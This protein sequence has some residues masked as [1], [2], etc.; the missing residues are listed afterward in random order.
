MERFFDND[1]EKENEFFDGAFNDD[2][3]DIDTDFDEEGIAY[4]D[5][6]GVMQI[7]NI[8]LART[9]HKQHIL[10]KAV[11]I[12][13]KSFFWRFK[14]VTKKMRDIHNVYE[15]LKVI[16]EDDGLEEATE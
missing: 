11:E 15:W 5:P 6:E 7:M 4:I 16:T 2:D 3:D 13:E 14:G 9:E 8:E 1:P 10:N 12:C